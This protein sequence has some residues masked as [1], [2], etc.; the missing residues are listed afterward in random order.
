MLEHIGAVDDIGMR[1]KAVAG[2]TEGEFRMDGLRHRDSDRGNIGSSDPGLGKEGVKYGQGI[3]QRAAK[4]EDREFLSPDVVEDHRGQQLA[5]H[6]CEK[7]CLPAAAF[8]DP[9][10]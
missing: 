9:I 2:N 5:H 1:H 6:F 3:A 7:S 10:L 8:C 4:V